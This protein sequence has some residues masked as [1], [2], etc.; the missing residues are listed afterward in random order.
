[1]VQRQRRQPPR[2]WPTP[3]LRSRAAGS[4]GLSRSHRDLEHLERVR[5]HGVVLRPRW[6]LAYAGPTV[7]SLA[8]HPSVGHVILRAGRLVDNGCMLGADRRRRA[9]RI[10]D[11]SPVG[12]R[13]RRRE[14]P[15][16]QGSG[17][18]SEVFRP[19]CQRNRHE[20]DRRK[21]RNIFRNF[22]VLLHVVELVL[23]RVERSS[24]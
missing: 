3:A 16:R 13:R 19:G 17:C 5:A 23:D 10:C 22:L 4:H 18:S 2:H 9:Q 12:V 8:K 1:V 11:L 7:V 21:E 14:R 20:T 24:C 15:W 6:Q